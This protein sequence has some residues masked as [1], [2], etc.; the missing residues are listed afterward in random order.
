MSSGISV[1]TV[2]CELY[3]TLR[4]GTAATAPG[5]QFVLVYRFKSLFLLPHWAIMDKLDLDNKNSSIDLN[6]FYTK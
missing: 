3:S 6:L 2:L 4:K 5:K 1:N